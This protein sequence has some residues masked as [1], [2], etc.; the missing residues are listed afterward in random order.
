MEFA[1]GGTV[2]DP[3]G[4]TRAI[5]EARTSINREDFGITWNMPL[6]NGGILVSKE[7]D[8]EIHVETV[9]ATPEG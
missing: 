9:L 2:D 8:V 5:Y 7:V 3:W 4:G 6:P 1:F